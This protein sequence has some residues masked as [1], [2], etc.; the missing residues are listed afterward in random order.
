[1]IDI[2]FFKKVN[3]TYG[4]DIGDKAIQI[5]AQTLNENTRNSDTIIRY[6]GEE[7]IVLL[8]NCDES[9]VVSVAEKIRTAF[10]KKNIPVTPTTTI[11]KTLSIGACVFP[12]DSIDLKECI[13]NADIALYE[14]KNS[15]RNKTVIFKKS[16]IKENN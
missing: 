9:S 12:K 7:F 15:G 16:M 10:M 1:M 6:G 14:A 13:K 2:D 4:H 3:D 11:N 8:H 5:V